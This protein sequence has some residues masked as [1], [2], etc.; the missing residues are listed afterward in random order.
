M[1]AWNWA[2]IPDITHLMIRVGSGMRWNAFAKQLTKE[3]SEAASTSYAGTRVLGTN[4]KSVA[5]HTTALLVF[6][7]TLVSGLALVCPIVL[8]HWN[9]IARSRYWRFRWWPWMSRWLTTCIY[10]RSNRW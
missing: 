7:I 9:L 5:W 3:M 8:G 10:L 6:P 2:F 4:G 1:Q